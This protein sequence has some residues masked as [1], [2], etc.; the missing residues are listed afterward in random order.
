M[1]QGQTLDHFMKKL[2]GAQGSQVENSSSKSSKFYFMLIGEL[3]T[4]DKEGCGAILADIR[5]EL[6]DI[7]RSLEGLKQVEEVVAG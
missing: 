2:L 5:S 6:S 3:C 7:V 4:Q 1:I